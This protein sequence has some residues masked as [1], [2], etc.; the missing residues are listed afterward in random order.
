MVFVCL[1][2]LNNAPQHFYEVSYTTIGG[3]MNTGQKNNKLNT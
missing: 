2:M 1:T 3:W